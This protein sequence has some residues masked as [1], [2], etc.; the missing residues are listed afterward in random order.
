MGRRING[1]VRCRKDGEMSLGRTFEGRERR[2][3]PPSR[4]RTFLNAV[5]ATCT[6]RLAQFCRDRHHGVRG[7]WPCYFVHL[8]RVRWVITGA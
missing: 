1:G 7:F 6:E 4:P 2:G 8:R 3:K 5:S